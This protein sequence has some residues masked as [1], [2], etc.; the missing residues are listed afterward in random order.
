[1]I[2]RRKPIQRTPLV[3]PT[4]EQVRAWESRP[5]KPIGRNS[6]PAKVGRRARREEAALAAGRAQ[7]IERSGDWCEG[8]PI[9]GVHRGDRHP[10]LHV[11]HVL[12]RGR[13]GKHAPSNL[14]HVCPDLHT[15]IHAWPAE[16][17]ALGLLRASRHPS[18]RIV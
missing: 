17:E 1:M 12:P 3:A 15:W 10:A 4:I 2:L 5:R 7:T 9:I 6:Q 16:A 18:E 8:P 14:L 13:G 11:H